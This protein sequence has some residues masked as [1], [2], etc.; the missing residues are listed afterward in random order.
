MV[1]LFVQRVAMQQTGIVG[2]GQ[3]THQRQIDVQG[4]K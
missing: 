4:T 2:D 3:G 1:H